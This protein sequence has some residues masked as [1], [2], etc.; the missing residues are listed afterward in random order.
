MGNTSN[1]LENAGQPSWLLSFWQ[2]S[3][4]AAST[5]DSWSEKPQIPIYLPLSLQF[6]V[7]LLRACN[8][9][10]CAGSFTHFPLLP[11]FASCFPCH[12]PH[13]NLSSSS[14]YALQAS[15]APNLDFCALQ[16]GI[17]ADEE[18]SYWEVLQKRYGQG[19]SKRDK[20]KHIKMPSRR[21]QLFFKH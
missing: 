7:F 19:L 12:I 15:S 4:G 11:F 13:T 10:S 9:L 2:H 21:F 8:P 1:L 18:A 16:S 5:V 3:L 6:P 20:G 17:S 14:R